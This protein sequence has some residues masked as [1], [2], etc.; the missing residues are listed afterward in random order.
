MTTEIESIAHFKG[1]NQVDATKQA[2]LLLALFE[3]FS[4][5]ANIELNGDHFD[6]QGD[7]FVNKA[8]DLFK[9]DLDE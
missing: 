3:G 7:Y 8:C 9:C 4:F 1:A 2:K 5:M 6:E